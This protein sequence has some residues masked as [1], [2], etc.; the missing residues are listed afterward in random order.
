VRTATGF[1]ALAVRIV[2]LTDTVAVIEGVD[3]GVE[4]ALV[5]PNAA[6]RRQPGSASP[7]GAL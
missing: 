5:N 4:V 2:A 7:R 6:Q 3:A 1:D